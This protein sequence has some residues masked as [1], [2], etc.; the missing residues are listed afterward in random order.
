MRVDGVGIRLARFC[1]S[2]TTV[3]KTLL[4]IRVIADSKCSCGPCLCIPASYL[5]PPFRFL[6]S[7]VPSRPARFFSPEVDGSNKAA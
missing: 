6:L 2:A 5:A 4:T 3:C 1:D 7:H